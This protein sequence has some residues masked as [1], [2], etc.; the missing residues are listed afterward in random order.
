MDLASPVSDPARSL[1]PNMVSCMDLLD[2]LDTAT[3]QKLFPKSLAYKSANVLLIRWDEDIQASAA[4]SELGAVFQDRFRF[5]I[6]NLTIPAAKAEKHLRRAMSDFIVK[7]DSADNHFILCCIGRADGDVSLK[8]MDIHEIVSFNKPDSSFVYL[9]DCSFDA[10]VDTAQRPCTATIE[11]LC[12]SQLERESPCFMRAVT[13]T[14]KSLPRNSAFSVAQLYELLVAQIHD[15]GVPLKDIQLKRGLL[16]VRNQSS[17]VLRAVVSTKNT[18]LTSM[19]KL[20]NDSVSSSPWKQPIVTACMLT[21]LVRFCV[22]VLATPELSHQMWEEWC[23]NGEVDNGASLLGL[24][25]LH[26]R[27]MIT[28]EDLH[29]GKT[30]NSTIWT[31]TVPSFVF[32]NSLANKPFIKHLMQVRSTSLLPNSRNGLSRNAAA[33][34]HGDDSPD[35]SDFGEIT[36]YNWWAFEDRHELPGLV[37]D[38]KHRDLLKYA[39]NKT[40]HAMYLADVGRWLEAERLCQD[41]VSRFEADHALL[42]ADSP[43]VLNALKNLAVVQF[44]QMTDRK[45]NDSLHNFKKLKGFCLAKYQASHTWS[46]LVE[47]RIAVVLIRLERLDEAVKILTTMIAFLRFVRPTPYFTPLTFACQYQLART[48]GL[49]S[50]ELDAE[51][52]YV[53]LINRFVE[54]YGLRHSMI[55]H[56]STALYHVLRRQNKNIEAGLVEASLSRLRSKDLH[57]IFVFV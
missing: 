3:G 24:S 8:F 53:D 48:Q 51:K 36:S 17:I 40:I 28:L 32:E 57:G 44:K 22:E 54:A 29:A 43:Y 9:L 16:G 30:S 15:A 26:V 45:L 2:L 10:V 7:H 49:L 39:E 1:E 35:S 21:A 5:S 12:T 13:A 37:D 33:A 14:I 23:Y 18:D 34:D 27:D 42:R 6:D 38:A 52:N 11:Y 56:A 46:L 55:I 41:V 19:A 47:L 31:M 25:S 20:C 50:L 4:L